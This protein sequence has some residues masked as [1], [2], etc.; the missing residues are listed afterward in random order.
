MS[1]WL[2]RFGRSNGQGQHRSFD[3]VARRRER[4]RG[5]CRNRARPILKPDLCRIDAHSQVRLDGGFTWHY[6]PA[7]DGGDGGGAAVHGRRTF[8]DIAGFDDIEKLWMDGESDA[9]DG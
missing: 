5:S 3:D 1:S 8:V 7:G 9:C 4:E 6:L 2:R